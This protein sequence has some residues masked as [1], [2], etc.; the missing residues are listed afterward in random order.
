MI[1]DTDNK[2]GAP[3]GDKE[4]SQLVHDARGHLNSIVMN[5]EL[6]RMLSE[7]T[8]GAERITRLMDVIIRQCGECDRLIEKFR[9]EYSGRG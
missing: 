9:Q 1:E 2:H 5:G 6:A 3:P 8:A 4:L 7:R